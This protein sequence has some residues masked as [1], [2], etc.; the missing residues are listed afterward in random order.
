LLAETLVIAG[1]RDRAAAVLDSAVATALQRHDVWWL[2]ELLRLRSELE[3]P[4][5]RERTLRQALEMAHAQKSRSLEERIAP[6]L[7]SK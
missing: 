7:S 3:P 5:A 2:P 6:A 4:Q 1:N